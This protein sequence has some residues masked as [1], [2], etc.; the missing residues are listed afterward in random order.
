V[1]VCVCVCACVCVCG[2]VCVR[3]CSCV[4]VCVLFSQG[5]DET[6]PMN[7]ICCCEDPTTNGLGHQVTVTTWKDGSQQEVVLIPKSA[8]DEMDCDWEFSSAIAHKTKLDDG[9]MSSSADQQARL[10]GNLRAEQGASQLRGEVVVHEPALRPM[11]MLA[12]GSA[13]P[14]DNDGHVQ[15]AQ[16][17]V[18]K[19]AHAVNPWPLFCNHV[20]LLPAW[21]VRRQHLCSKR[22]V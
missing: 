15:Q 11:A 1:C 5:R 13:G 21:S 7:S 10:Y 16:E 20:S 19:C 8:S 17:S 3:V 22:Y 4:C 14:V 9:S 12:A 2:C 6:K 18:L